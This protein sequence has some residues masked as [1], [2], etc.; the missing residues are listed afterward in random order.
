MGFY[1]LLPQVH[2]PP[3]VAPHVDAPQL[4]EAVHVPLHLPQPVPAEVTS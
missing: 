1:P 2:F 3:L 4:F